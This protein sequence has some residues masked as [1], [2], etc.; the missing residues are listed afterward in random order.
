MDAARRL[1]RRMASWPGNVIR[2]LDFRRSWAS[3]RSRRSKFEI[4]QIM[5]RTL[6]IFLI[7]G[8][9][10]CTGIDILPQSFSSGQ[11]W[12]AIIVI[13]ALSIVAV[14][15]F[16]LR[17]ARLIDL[18]RSLARIPRLTQVGQR[19]MTRRAWRKVESQRQHCRELFASQIDFSKVRHPGLQ[20]P[21][22]PSSPKDGA[23]LEGP[24]WEAIE[25]M[26]MYLEE[27]LLQAMPGMKRPPGSS[28]RD[29]LLLAAHE[30]IIKPEN[31]Q[32]LVRLADTYDHARY[33]GVSV[34]ENEVLELME[35]LWTVMVSIQPLVYEGLDNH[36]P[37][38]ILTRNTLSAQDTSSDRIFKDY[39]FDYR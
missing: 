3:V 18:R 30:G 36:R 7:L 13:I 19:D 34:T 23:W 15:A 31:V 38:S 6:M 26:P 5:S 12:N 21:L 17:V 39:D 4:V 35:N 29:Y 2:I 22:L 37:D 16:A 9:I 24:F 11:Y 10:S 32:D 14:W 1:R 25:T 20:N 33:A 27:I 28:L 8:A